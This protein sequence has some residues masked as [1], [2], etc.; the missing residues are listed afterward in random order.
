MIL[1]YGEVIIYAI[2][3]GCVIL[4]NIYKSNK[5]DFGGKGK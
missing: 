3:I 5:S 2:L 1:T 4:F